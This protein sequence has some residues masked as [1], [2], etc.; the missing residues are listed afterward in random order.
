MTQMVG[1]A[2]LGSIPRAWDS[3][4]RGR[5]EEI[6]DPGNRLAIPRRGYNP[7]GGWPLLCSH[8]CC[9]RREIN[10]V[11]VIPVFSGW[12][13]RRS[14]TAIQAIPETL[15]T[16]QIIIKNH[17][18]RSGGLLVLTPKIIGGD[19]RIWRAP[20][21]PLLRGVLARF[22]CLTEFQKS[23]IGPRGDSWERCGPLS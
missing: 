12:Q 21:A 9:H 5:W 3:Q 22:W 7:D 11:G 4:R 13:S 2:G 15:S 19:R 6:V 23:E 8:R 20:G 17:P 14:D 10:I 1:E 16:N 18:P